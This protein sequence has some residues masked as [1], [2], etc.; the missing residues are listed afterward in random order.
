M[1]EEF[2]HQSHTIGRERYNEFLADLVTD[3]VRFFEQNLIFKP[4][5]RLNRAL[6]L[7]LDDDADNGERSTDMGYS[8]MTDPRNRKIYLD[9]FT[10]IFQNFENT[11]SLAH[12][13]ETEEKE[14]HN[15][16][17]IYSIKK[18]GK[19]AQKEYVYNV[20]RWLDLVKCVMILCCGVYPDG[21]DLRRLTIDNENGARN[22]FLKILN[23]KDGGTIQREMFIATAS[24]EF[25]LVTSIYKP[26]VRHRV[27]P[28]CI[29]DA[30]VVYLIDVVPYLSSLKL[31]EYYQQAKS[32]TTGTKPDW[33]N[34]WAGA[35]TYCYIA[36]WTDVLRGEVRARLGVR[37]EIEDIRRMWVWFHNDKMTHTTL[38][39]ENKDMQGHLDL[40]SLKNFTAEVASRS[41][42]VNLKRWVS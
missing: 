20:A 32:S 23:R 36:D 3:T 12:L 8:F 7:G 41:L 28:H 10:N 33:N 30:M 18:M 39:T 37:M 17:H 35:E 24:M 15:T 29:G 14:V 1:A 13:I 6:L 34:L 16:G 4:L 2:T 31:A 42:G 9:G 5:S 21:E 38:R 19:A 40:R 25:D 22:I 26:N 27:L 11:P